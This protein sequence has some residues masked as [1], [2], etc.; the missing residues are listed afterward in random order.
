MITL[1]G[2]LGRAAGILLWI[3]ALTPQVAMAV[4]A[5]KHADIQALMQETGMLAN[6]NR[7]VELLMPQV[8]NSLKKVNP[9]IPQATWDDF[10]RL[11]SEEFKKSLAELQEPVITIFDKNF[12]DGEIKQLIAFYKTPLGQKVVTQMPVVMQQSAQLGQAWGQQ[13]G[14]RVAERIRAAAKQKGYEL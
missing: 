8:I 7:T 9:N 2:H 3:S 13:V 12:T 11:G 10:S 1:A 5:E 4:E 6:M 14:A